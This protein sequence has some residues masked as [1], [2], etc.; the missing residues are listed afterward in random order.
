M[1]KFLSI[2][3]T[4]C[5]LLAPM[6]ALAESGA[7]QL[8]IDMIELTIGDNDPIELDL[9][10]LLTLLNG[11]AGQ[12]LSL[13]VNDAEGNPILAGG[14]SVAED[15]LTGVING[16]SSAYRISPEALQEALASIEEELGM[17]VED[18]LNQATA[19]GQALIDALTPSLENLSQVIS[20]VISEAEV[21]QGPVEK[22]SVL[23][24]EYEL[25][26]A[27]MTLTTEQF[28]RITA[29]FQQMLTDLQAAAPDQVDMDVD[30]SDL[31]GLETSLDARVWANDDLSVARGEFDLNLTK[32]GETITLPLVLELVD[33]PQDGTNAELS[34]AQTTDDGEAV[35]ASLS[36][37]SVEVDGASSTAVML[38]AYSLDNQENEDQLFVSLH[39]DTTAE[40]ETSYMLTFNGGDNDDQ[41]ESGVYYSFA[42]TE[43]EYG[44]NHDAYMNL[45]LTTIEDGATTAKYEIDFLLNLANR[46]YE[47]DGTLALSLPVVD[48]DQ[49]TDEQAEQ[50]Q[51]E[52]SAVLQNAMFA[53]MND[54]G[55]QQLISLFTAPAQTDA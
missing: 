32:D 38:S 31:E 22:V 40:G 11:D 41:F 3:L 5:L 45:W 52:I 8:T 49:M 1:K 27:N 36:Y 48:L 53:L 51:N 18:A 4:L 26:R 12:S 30:V 55:V 10:L 47:T 2:L 19:S 23:D 25:Q 6:G 37:S 21:T 24:K 16:M 46:A 9:S 17:P 54:T 35:Y 20:E 43:D 50:A 13:A 44:K 33:N 28:S 34:L 7:T 15:G 29:A 39:A 14:L 42:N